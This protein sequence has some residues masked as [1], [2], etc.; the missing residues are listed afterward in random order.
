MRR[1]HV[2][3]FV[4]LFAASVVLHPQGNPTP[5]E[6]TDGCERLARCDDIAQ[7]AAAM[8]DVEVSRSDSTVTH[9]CCP[10]TLPA[11]VVQLT[12]SF[13]DWPENW[14]PDQA[15]R[16]EL[17]RRGWQEV[18]ACAA[19]GPDGTQFALRTGGVL[20]VFEG[21]WEGYDPSDSTHV[22]DDRY[23]LTAWCVCGEAE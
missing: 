8:P 4:V 21:R 11:C 23:A 10:D 16:S 22:P 15:L 9:Q 3:A 20:C 14:S 13:A 1:R 5:R 17:T 18:L 7:L 6:R 12:G 2:F 19:D